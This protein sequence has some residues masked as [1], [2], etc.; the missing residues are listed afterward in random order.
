MTPRAFEQALADFLHEWRSG[1]P[2]LWVK[3]SGS[4][5]TPKRFQ[6]GKD[7]MRASARM[8]CDYLGLQSGD[9]ALLCMSLDYI[10]GKMVVVRAEERGLRLVPVA[11]CGHPF[12]LLTEAPTFAAVVPLQVYNTLQIPE[13][14]E[15]MMRVRHL[16][17]GG[18]AIDDAMREAL[19]SFPNAVWSS[20]GMTET[21][22]HIALRRINGPDAGEWYRPL[23]GITLKLSPEGTLM[24]HAPHLCEEDLVTRDV[25]ELRGDQSFRILGR[26]DNIINS[27]GIKIQLEEVEKLLHSH[28]DLPFQFTAIPD[29]KFGELLVLLHLPG[30]R[31][32]L[33]PLCQAHLP[34][35]WR[36]KRFIEVAALPLTGTIKPDRATARRLAGGKA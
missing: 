16:L 34:I 7:R 27:G 3:S 12:A 36:P 23:S 30:G 2:L 10:A 17:I 22:S 11:P 5:G 9:T 1:D 19:Q 26:L 33:E 29:P 14:R 8:T 6:V 31:K 35:Y 20:Y 32:I 13:E 15:R 25:A 24:I 4:T 28:T 21:L 18:G